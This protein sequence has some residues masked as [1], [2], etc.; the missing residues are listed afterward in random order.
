MNLEKKYFWIPGKLG[1][2]KKNPGIW[3]ILVLENTLEICSGI[4]RD[5][6]LYLAFK[7]INKLF[8]ALNYLIFTFFRYLNFR[9]NVK[10]LLFCDRFCLKIVVSS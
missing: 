9:K 8:L 2:H 4:F 5:G 10:I 3:E 6:C 1:Q 7:K